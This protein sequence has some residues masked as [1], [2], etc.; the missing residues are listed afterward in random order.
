M[1]E[2]NQ[3]RQIDCWLAPFEFAAFGLGNSVRKSG[4]YNRCTPR[5]RTHRAWTAYPSAQTRYLYASHHGCHE[6]S[7]P[8]TLIWTWM[9]HRSGSKRP[10]GGKVCLN[11]RFRTNVIQILGYPP[12]R[13]HSKA[14]SVV[15]V[16]LRHLCVGGAT[17]VARQMAGRNQRKKAYRRNCSQ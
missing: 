15:N 9:T 7:G 3:S 5:L 1:I 12:G 17:V 6:V 10:I 2:I 11:K 4:T 16:F 8:T 13:G 14:T